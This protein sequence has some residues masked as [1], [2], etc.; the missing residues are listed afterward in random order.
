M[1]IRIVF[2]TG[3]ELIVD[4]FDNDFVKR[5]CRLLSQEIACGSL[6]QE[7]TYSNFAP[8]PLAKQRLEEAI[9]SVNDFLKRKFISNPCVSDYDNPDFYNKLHEQFE[10][11]T[12]ADWDTPTR[13][14]VL[15]PDHIKLA[16]KQINRYCHRLE[17]RPYVNYSEMRIEFNTH[18]RE[19][20]TNE[21]Y[22][23]F[24]PINESNAV[25]LDYS[26]LGKSLRECFE[27][28][29]DADYNGMKVQQ[30]YCANFILQF[31]RRPERPGFTHWCAEQGI[32][33]IPAA[34][35][36]QLQIGKIRDQE[37]SDQVQKTAK[38]LDI[39]LE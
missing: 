26:T 35:Q 16:I 31:E 13:L 30:H 14:M 3:Y 25:V 17:H 6:L 18:R 1:K 20:L 2:D 21:D 15:A 5:W 34:E 28:G 29:L 9:D 8:E 10:K 33:E 39:I 11:L 38:I 23:L 7:D 22:K 36:G 24:Q 4:L 32:I 27:D 19:L 37:S 12:G